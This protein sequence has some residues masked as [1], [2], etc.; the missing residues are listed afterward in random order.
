LGYIAAA[1][2]PVLIF[3]F[4]V[5]LKIP[6]RF[7]SVFV[8]FAALV[9]FLGASSKK[10]NPFRLASAGFLGA[11]GLVCFLSNSAL[12]LKLYPVLMNALMLGAFAFTL[13]FPPPM[14]FR[15][16]VL[17]D[18]SIPGSLGEKRVE[19][20][21][22]KVT[23]VWCAFFALN[24]AAAAWTVFSGS[25]ALWS[26]YNGGVSYILI[27]ILFAGEFIVRKMTDKKMPKAIPL[28]V[29]SAG[30]RPP[31][32]V[33]CYERAFGDGVY[34]TW[35]D[36][37][38]DTA[39]L[40]LAIERGGA[41]KWILHAG[42]YWYFL[43][44]FT[45][46]LQRGRE[47]LL[48]ANISPAYLAEIRAGE[49]A[50]FITDQTRDGGDEENTLYIPGVLEGPLPPGADPRET[51]PIKADETVIVMYTSGST[52]RPKAV[53]Q[54][55]TE[56]EN[57]NRFVLSRWGEEW[58]RRKV[59]ATVSQHHIYGLLFSILLPFTSGVPFRR[60]RI[61][62]PEELEALGDEPYLII[63]VPAFLKRAVELRESYG[64]KDPWI[65]SSGGVLER[66]TARK[67][68]AVFGFWPLEVYGSTETSGI[69]WRQSKDGLE[70]TPFDNAEVKLDERGRLLIRSPYIKDPEGFS[71]EDL[72]EIL[73]N[74]RFLLKGRADSVVK[75]EE[76]R[77]SLPEIEERILSSGMAADA[78][79]IALEGRRQYLGAA[80][81]LNSEGVRRFE[82]GE[83]AGVNRWFRE[84]LARFF[85]PVALPKKWRYVQS[86]PL[87]SQG[88][89]KRSAV[90]ALF[91]Q[92]VLLERLLQAEKLVERSESQAV[93]EFAVPPESDY[94][95]DHFP[96]LKVLPAV[97]QFELAVRFARRYLGTE[98]WV[99]RAKRLK[100]SAPVRPG[101]VLRLTLEKSGVPP[102]VNFSFSSS[103]GE[104]AYSSGS[105]V[106]EG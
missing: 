26:F 66:E 17:A 89:K 56:F 77:V 55:L 63:T 104:R 80:L 27:G 49:D 85:E 90:E 33:L 91:T 79:V 31:D 75:I 54:R 101:A 73:P 105:F 95:N 45:A 64:L 88:K 6:L 72:A 78:A 32:H 19:R 86:L 60:R 50:A 51:P 81:V 2:Y 58:L 62:A 84:Y 39:R 9:V 83:K 43:C 98:L 15:F 87:D 37:L 40:R 23:L 22:R 21:C 52:G 20:Y 16:A 5:I 53:R 82:G 41:E 93:L 34:K 10:T 74:G 4:L 42:D 18:K 69:A 8:V 99:A 100:F 35:D 106:P 68:E 67:T 92:D 57:D 71:S 46:L 102:Q 25:D 28:S 61:E 11:A 44:A 48:T 29:F 7:V 65:Y 70:W 14:I 36:F 97:A 38:S 76:K 94:F 59:C 96:A 30:S 47:I 13:W 103:G 12:F 1:V 3:C 24:G